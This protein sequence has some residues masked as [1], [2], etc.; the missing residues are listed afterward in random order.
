MGKDDCDTVKDEDTLNQAQTKSQ[1]RKSAAA[2]ACAI[3]IGGQ[4][5][6]G[7]DM[8]CDKIIV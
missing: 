3:P 6:G 4:Y 5:L 8:D 7:N 1:E 2:S